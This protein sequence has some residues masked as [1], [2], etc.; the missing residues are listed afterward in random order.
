VRFFLRGHQ[1]AHSTTGDACLLS[2]READT[3]TSHWPL[4]FVRRAIGWLAGG[5]LSFV[6]LVVLVDVEVARVLALGLTGT[7]RTPRQSEQRY[8]RNAVGSRGRYPPC[9]SIARDGYF[10]LPMSIEWLSCR[11]VVA[12][13]NC[14]SDTMGI[15]IHQIHQ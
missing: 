3:Y 12:T 1:E 13:K 10:L 2:R 5:K 15:K 6:E 11:C 14:D 8:G 4:T 7:D 9:R